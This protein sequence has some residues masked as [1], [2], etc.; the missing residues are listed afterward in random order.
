M[1]GTK[2]EFI[3][4]GVLLQRPQ[5]GYDLNT[6][7]EAEGRF[8]RTNTSMT[9][10]YRALRTMENDGWLTHSVEP[11]PGAK[12][13]KRY[14]VTEQGRSVFMEWLAEPYVPAERPADADFYTRLRFRAAHLGRDSV[15]QLLEDEIA[16]RYRQIAR[17]RHRDRSEWVDPPVPFDDAFAGAVM[18]WVHVQGV[19][20][21]DRHLEACTELRDILLSGGIPHPE[22]ANPLLRGSE[23]EDEGARSPM[24]EALG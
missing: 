17:N 16:H 8:M 19:A 1:R 23:F 9:Q 24:R 6:F 7:M 3:L 5:T 14:R 12:D 20:R 22:L 15:L 21:M 2:L 10:V 13:A 4:M 18:N 11:R